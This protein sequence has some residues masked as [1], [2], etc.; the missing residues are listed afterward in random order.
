MRG[1]SEIGNAVGHDLEP[2][3]GVLDV[4]VYLPYTHFPR[5]PHCG[6][7]HGQRLRL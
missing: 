4:S 2:L 5:N 6:G 7:A 1:V 3:R